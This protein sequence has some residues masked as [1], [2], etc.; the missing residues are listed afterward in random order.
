[1][2]FQPIFWIILGAQSKAKTVERIGI[3][4]SE[5]TPKTHTYMY[6]SY[7]DDHESPADWFE[8]S[9]PNVIFA[10]FLWY[11]ETQFLSMNQIEADDAVAAL[12]DKATSVDKAGENRKSVAG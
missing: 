10:W 5:S 2:E 1:M 8:N 9:K 6:V 11:R 4:Q 12:Q 3:C 7:E